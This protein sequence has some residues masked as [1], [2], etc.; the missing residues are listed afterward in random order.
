MIKI[1]VKG[2]ESDQSYTFYKREIVIGS[3][4]LENC[5]LFL[6]AENLKPEHIKIEEEKERFIIRNIAGDPF[7]TLNDLPFGKRILKDQDVIQI[8]RTTLIFEGFLTKEGNDVHEYPVVSTK[9]CLGL[10]VDQAI[11]KTTLMENFHEQQESLFEEF[12]ELQENEPGG[13]DSGE[14]EALLEEWHEIES[15]FTQ[16][17]H[18]EEVHQPESP[19]PVP[20]QKKTL[21]YDL[22]DNDQDPLPFNTKPKEEKEH[23]TEAPSSSHLFEH[24]PP[25]I[26]ILIITF[27]LGMLI[28][29]LII[30][31]SFWKFNK[32]SEQKVKQVSRGIADIAFA[33][34]YAKI[35]HITPQQHNWSSPQFLKTSISSSLSPY[36]YSNLKLEGN[37]KIHENYL[38]RIYT[39]KE[40]SRFVIIAQPEP[41]VFHYFT[42]PAS[43][44]VDSSLMTLQKVQD[45]KALN[46]LLIDPEQLHNPG[47]DEVAQILKSNPI[48]SMDSLA[49]EHNVNG[50]KT[51]DNLKT[52][53]PGAENYI[54]NS[55]RYSQVGEKVMSDALELSLNSTPHTEVRKIKDLLLSI[56]KLPFCVLYTTKGKEHAAMAKAAVSALSPDNFLIAYIDY[57]HKTH[58]IKSF[59]ITEEEREASS[60]KARNEETSL[61]PF[62]LAARAAAVSYLSDE[63]HLKSNFNRDISPTNPLFAQLNELS[64]KRK[65][66]LTASKEE[67]QTA[68]EQEI[69]NPSSSPKNKIKGKAES[70]MQKIEELNTTILKELH[71][72]YGQN[73]EIPLA[74][75]L[76][77]VEKSGLKSLANN[78]FFPGSN[79]EMPACTFDE[80]GNRALSAIDKALSFGALFNAIETSYAYFSCDRSE[81]PQHIMGYQNQVKGKVVEKLNELILLGPLSS[82]DTEF[83]LENHEKLLPALKKAWISDNDEQNFYLHEFK[84]RI[85]KPSSGS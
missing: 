22:T 52:L 10:I 30:A 6:P 74:E 3:S 70:L 59:L 21:I 84:L 28:F 82:E 60:E 41:S 69:E 80:E 18:F 66:E 17:E 64:A 55:P 34:T 51:P 12:Q 61:S 45:L 73:K 78:E 9:G 26:K 43:V 29:F 77:Y 72:L 46:R 31:G 27:A 2:T 42:T 54:Y 75:F 16:K 5:D 32:E 25:K 53:Y 65:R 40:N 13:L 49:D 62:H 19:D 38:L 63:R 47:R 24:I 37:G 57:D 4:E 33:L 14:V 36:H 23:T 85:I 11:N 20:Q 39:N 8:G 48:I 68:I 7:V 71:K 1:T 67:L 58:A 44:V 56:T 15:E 50:F 83:S 81:D 79:K 76:E 35:H